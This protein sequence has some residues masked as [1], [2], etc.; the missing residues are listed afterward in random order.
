[1]LENL[2]KRRSIR[3]FS[4]TPVEEDAVEKLVQGLLLSPSG[5]NIKPW[6]FILVDNPGLI[7]ELSVSKEHGSAFVAGAPLVVVILGNTGM[8]DVWVED[9]SVA[10]TICH[11]L[12][13]DLGLGSCWVQIRNR[14]TASGT[15]SGDYI[16]GLLDIP[17]AYEVEA[18]IAVGYGSKELPPYSRESLEY[19]KVH[20]NTFGTPYRPVQ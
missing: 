6:E 17:G 11:L 18:L 7:R 5:H 15:P 10:A 16:R 20:R 13:Q 12:A 3:S 14:K 9:T 19:G 1:M 8:T 2:Y 4:G